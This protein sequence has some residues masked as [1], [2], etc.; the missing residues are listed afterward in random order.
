MTLSTKSA[1]LAV[2]CALCA[3]LVVRGDNPNI[4]FILADDLGIGDTGITHQNLRASQGLPSFATPNIDSIALAGA[5]YN[6]MYAGGQNCSPSRVT[7]MTGFH[8]RHSI[9]ET[10]ILQ[11]DIRGGNEDRTWGQVLKDAGYATGMFGKWHMGGTDT[12]A[13]SIR[14]P[15]ALPTQKGFDTAYGPMLRWYRMSYHWEND[16]TGGMK[17]TFTPSE[18]TW[19]GTGDKNTYGEILVAQHAV[20]FIRTRANTG[21]PFA[22]YIPFMAPHDPI[23]QVPKDH[24]YI[25]MPWPQV[26]RDYAGTIW[27]LDQHVGQILGALDDPNNDGSTADSVANNT[28]VIFASDNGPLIHGSPSGFQPEFFNSNISYYGYKNMTTEG[29]IRSPFFIKWPEKIAPGTQNNVF[30]S[31][32]DILPTFAELTGADTPLGIDGRS[33]LSEW[34]GTGPRELPDSM[35]WGMTREIGPG[36]PASST[37]RVGPWKLTK[38]QP[39]SVYPTVTYWLFNIAND[40]NETVNWAHA[41]PDLVAALNQILVAE[42]ADREP[43]APLP[44]A[45]SILGRVNTYFTQ[46]KSWAPSPGSTD[47]FSAGNWA[48]GTQYDF[49]PGEPEAN[50]WNTGPADNWLATMVNATATP[51]EVSLSAN[52]AVLALGVAGGAAEMRLVVPAGRT[53]T[54][55]N[56]LRISAGGRVKLN[57]GEINTIREVEIRPGGALDAQGTINGQQHILAPFAD[58]AG[59]RLFEPKLTNAGTLNVGSVA[60]A[61]TLSILG[62]YAQ[63]TTGTLHFDL[64]ASSGGPGV[65]FDQLVVQRTA[66]LSGL[67]EIALAPG[68]WQP[69]LG[70]TFQI[71]T[72]TGGVTGTFSTASMPPLTPGW[73]WNILYSANSVSLQV[74]EQTLSSLIIATGQP[75]GSSVTIA[76]SQTL[77]LAGNLRVGQGA[78]QGDLTVTTGGLVHV[79]GMT[80]LDPGGVVTLAGGTL[81]TGAISH[82]AGGTLDWQS[83]VLNVTGALQVAPGQGMGPIVAIGANQTLDVDGALTVADGVMSVN[84]GGLVLAD[85]G[86][87]IGASGTLTLAGGTLATTTITNNAGGSFDW[88]S[89]TLRFTGS[90]AT[91]AGAPLGA[92]P[93]IGAARRLEVMNN[94]SVG[95][96]GAAGALTIAAG[97]Q[98]AVANQTTIGSAGV[99]TLAG[100]TLSTASLQNTLGGTFDW[101]SGV[102]HFSGDLTV[103]AAGNLGANVS[104]SGGRTLEVANQLS[105]A[106]GGALAV[107]AGGVVT[108]TNATTIASGGTL[109]LTGGLLSTATLVTQGG[110][111]FNWTG[112]TLRFTND[113]SVSATGDLGGAV[114][115]G[116]SRT[117]EVVDD[118]GVTGGALTIN[119]AGAVIVGDATTLGAGATLTLDGGTLTTATLETTGGGAFVWN[120]GALHLTS[121]L[122]MAAGHAF[123][124]I[125]MGAGKS[126]SAANLRIGDGASVGVLTVNAGASVQI[127][128]A[129]LVDPGGLLDIDGGSF[130]TGSL[131]VV[132]PGSVRFNAGALAVTGP[133]GLVIGAAGPLGATVGV[134][135]GQTLSVTAATSIASGAALSVHGGSFTTGVLELNGGTYDAVNLN[136]VGAVMFNAGLIKLSG[137]Q[138]LAGNGPLGPEVAIG[139]GQE[140]EVG[141][142]LDI[143][144]AGNAIFLMIDAGGLID[145]HAATN[146]HSGSVLVLNGGTLSTARLIGEPGALFGW[147]SGTLH[148]TGDLGVAA[149][150]DLGS[151]VGIASD[152]TLEVAGQLNVGAGLLGVAFQGNVAVGGTTRVADGGTIQLTGGKFSTASLD[153][154]PGGAFDW[155][156]GEL[157]FTGDQ[158][159]AAAGP[160]TQALGGSLSIGPARYLAIVGTATLNAPL[161]IAGGTLSVGQ[162]TN[163]AMLDFSTGTLNITGSDL[164]VGSGGAFGASLN[165]A[166]TAAL[167]VSGGTLIAAGALT[168]VADGGTLSSQTIVNNGEL[169]L[170]GST[171]SA[172]VG[173]S[174]TNGGMLRGAGRVSGA[175]TNLAAGSIVADAGQ[176]LNLLGPT[177]ANA[178]H[179]IATGGLTGQ[180]EIDFDG[181]VT[182]AAGTGLISAANGQ[183]R[184]NGG[185]ANAGGLAVTG[186][187]GH[188]YGNIINT[189]ELLVTGGATATFYG[190][191]VQN[192][193]LRVSKVGDTTSVAVFLGAVTGS[194]GS[195]GDG[196]IFFEGDLRPGNSPAQV[197]YSNNVFFGLNSQID[198][199]LGGL[200]VG[201]QYDQIVVGGALTLGGALDVQLINGFTPAAGQNFT[202]A[203]AAGGISGSFSDML[204]PNLP[205]LAWVLQRQPTSLVLS[206]RAATADFDGNGRVDGRDF[207]AWQRGL[208]RISATP[209][210]G[211][212]NGDGLVNAAD[213]TIWRSA[214]TGGGGVAAAQGVPEPA[215]ACLVSMAAL[216]LFAAA[217]RPRGIVKRAR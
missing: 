162:L 195:T 217:R 131:A 161:A 109:S 3:A 214:M 141:G 103:S 115:I 121:N 36:T 156:F 216:V 23:D 203:T 72:A 60:T 46:Y 30:G 177:L 16:G 105:V 210:D 104:I 187:A 76:A 189:G 202:I 15:S 56:G 93:T 123:S 197:T 184:F 45:P 107:G 51:Q 171:A 27:Y 49:S 191:V 198:I 42:G 43:Y 200:T 38:N 144:Q 8:S 166:P 112:G 185:L 69:Q 87:V 118:L 157:R 29:G 176:R 132:A 140:L 5:R 159:I 2:A 32:A 41:K 145:A 71:L 196:D 167:H 59:M 168:S 17:K 70:D 86:L 119:N 126:L 6:N 97:G 54:A 9:F 10:G 194:G 129:T 55:R 206:V 208:G 58:F 50:N 136:G 94:L 83:G 160:V 213:L 179:V 178:G 138:A 73:S 26:Q 164:L 67:L 153:I 127:A 100:G 188:V 124:T 209:A 174:L 14:T 128:G 74:V 106:S 150:G 33:M 96:G 61:G 135:P 12:F 44:E 172:T 149:A 163:A 151:T 117:L 199:E 85:A 90:L 116:A 215:S 114:A 31:F 154:A 110:G 165:V 137:A 130:A 170:G 65:A 146:V 111:T 34:T 66:V 37:I 186:G 113:L 52:S 13:S 62:E 18:P 125:A 79:G 20:D 99:L 89:G 80:T 133:G 7:L 147:N 98:V 64:F 11:P 180:A 75:L 120:T 53:L 84:A 101:Q 39:T 205:G 175:V 4:V 155:Q 190:D 40:P 22:A 139:A 143:G 57:G 92:T 192:G 21:Q 25:N 169:L 63:S 19:T 102:L 108:T 77:D 68:G 212:G 193:V 158:A 183:L 152:Q 91:A 82:S 134:T 78:S 182:N 1:F 173:V 28:I 47:F 95:Q 88:S 207:M 81:K 122:T 24:P 148:F 204:L 48:G 142:P 211:D 201:A 35:S 181:A